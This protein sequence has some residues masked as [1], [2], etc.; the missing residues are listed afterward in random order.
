MSPIDPRRPKK[1]FSEVHKSAKQTLIDIQKE[2]DKG[3][4]EPRSKPYKELVPKLEEQ[5][6]KLASTLELLYHQHIS[7]AAF[8]GRREEIERAELLELDLSRNI[9]ESPRLKTIEE[10]YNYFRA[11]SKPTLLGISNRAFK[12]VISAFG[13]ILIGLITFT[14]RNLSIVPEKY[15]AQA[16]EATSSSLSIHPEHEASK[17]L[18]I[19]SANRTDSVL[20]ASQVQVLT[21]APAAMPR[22]DASPQTSASLATSYG[23]WIA[24]TPSVIRQPSIVIQ[25]AASDVSVTVNAEEVVIK[26]SA[27]GLLRSA[28]EV[29]PSSDEATT[30]SPAIVDTAKLTTVTVGHTKIKDGYFIRA[31]GMWRGRVLMNMPRGPQPMSADNMYSI[32][33]EK[34]ADTSYTLQVRLPYSKYSNGPY[35]DLV[36]PKANILADEQAARIIQYLRSRGVID[37][38]HDVSQTVRS[39]SSAVMKNSTVTDYGWSQNELTEAIIMA[40]ESEPD[41]ELGF[42]GKKTSEKQRH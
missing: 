27:D 18:H 11:I 40:L 26:L 16:I 34:S 1:N 31:D 33:I 4:F 41:N 29:T 14:I 19:T 42:H 22:P 3:D 24:P 21:T 25:M 5:L 23:K 10:A 35:A 7:T 15:R 12:L 38:E 39:Y 17:K 8:S 6:R 9:Y 37:G 30:M 36:Q 2:Q 32:A 13:V 28:N 20:S